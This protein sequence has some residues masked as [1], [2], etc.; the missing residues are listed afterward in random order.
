YPPGV[1]NHLDGLD[2]GYL[3]EEPSTARVHKH[4]VALH[5][6]QI[7]GGDSLVVR[8]LTAGVL[9]KETVEG[10]ART[11]KDG[12]DVFIPRLPNIIKELRAALL[13]EGH[14]RIAQPIE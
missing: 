6:E 10:F 2:S 8:E 7:E 1:H 11:I 12:M 3:V 14:H 4:G 9:G 13:V 5:F